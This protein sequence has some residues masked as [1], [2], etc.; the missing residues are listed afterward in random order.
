MVMTMN[1]LSPLV[2]SV[3]GNSGA[4]KTTLIERLLREFSR[5]KYRV[6]AVKHCPH[7]FDLDVEGKDSWRFTRAGASGVFLTSPGRVGLIEDKEPVP[8]LKSIAE[9]YFPSFDIVLGE[10]FSEEKEVT[11]IVVLRKGIRDYVQSPQD[12]I[13]ALVSDFEIKADKPLF[14]PDDVSG[15]ADFIE[16]LLVAESE[17][18][19]SVTLIINEKPVPLNAFVQGVFKNVIIGIIDTLKREDKKLKQIDVIIKPEDGNKRGK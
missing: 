15:I 5:R 4:G 11:K 3:V 16:R 18:E 17:A 9:Y 10:G 12:D 13:L 2:V 8:G 6:A 14:K 7:G 1:R 19:S